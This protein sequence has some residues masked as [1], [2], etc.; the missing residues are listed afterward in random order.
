[1]TNPLWNP[2][3]D[4]DRAFLRLAYN[5]A[6]KDPHLSLL[7][8]S[9]T[10]DAEKWQGNLPRGWTDE[11][12]K[13]FWDSLTG[14]N[15]HKVTRCM[16]QMKG[17]VDDTGAFCASL[18]DK[19]DPGWR[20]RKATKKEADDKTLLN[21]VLFPLQPHVKNWR[22][23]IQD[24]A[25]FMSD[26]VQQQPMTPVHFEVLFESEATATGGRAH[27]YRDSPT[28]YD[29]VEVTVPEEVEKVGKIEFTYKEF[30]LAVLRWVGSDSVD[31]SKRAEFL[32]A[33]TDLLKD[34]HVLGVL[35]RLMV[36]HAEREYSNPDMWEEVLD[37]VHRKYD[38]ES[39]T[40]K[41]AVAKVQPRFT[42]NGFSFLVTALITFG[43]IVPKFP[44]YEPDYDDDSYDDYGNPAH[45]YINASKTAR[46]QMLLTQADRKRLPALYSQ[47]NVKDPI[48]WVKFFNPYG[49]GTW[50]ATEFDGN[51]T[52][53]GLVKLHG[54]SELGYFSLR[55]LE[56]AKAVIGGRAHPGIQGVERDA[57]FRPEPLSRAKS[58]SAAAHR[59][60]QKKLAANPLIPKAFAQEIQKLHQVAER[61][62][63]ELNRL[64]PQVQ[65]QF[66]AVEEMDPRSR[67]TDDQYDDWFESPESA[68]VRDARQVLEDLWRDL[69]EHQ[70]GEHQLK[71]KMTRLVE[72]L[73]DW[74]LFL[75]RKAG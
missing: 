53:F 61:A 9:I 25:A 4:L 20:S 17:K 31:S 69:D 21:K 14:E 50:L 68:H 16:A 32:L 55:E 5:L 39:V 19:V 64:A 11:S 28:E 7:M 57:W 23:F 72:A 45:D 30:A 56:N 37:D 42:G 8:A 46:K 62:L 1:M 48:V 73:E 63:D 58:A 41:R 49:D 67:M 38:L 60:A 44:E 71:R 29:E 47:E 70:G 34:R 65:K 13:K 6:A 54:N 51:D 40:L 36:A 18:A 2:N 26:W 15:K 3:A 33:F 27:Y 12:V 52:F 35:I 24:M 59:V 43:E 22:I 66:Y 75:A 74:S 10:K